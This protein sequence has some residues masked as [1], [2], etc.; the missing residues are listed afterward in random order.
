MFKARRLCVSFN[1]RL[2]SNKEEEEE[3][4]LVRMSPRKALRGGISKSIFTR[5]VNF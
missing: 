4:V 3:D 1:S 5:F 2:E